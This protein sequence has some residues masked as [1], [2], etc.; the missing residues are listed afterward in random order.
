M[1]LGDPNAPHLVSADPTTLDDLFRHAAARR[2]DAVA[3]CD[4]PNRADCVDGEP[5]RLT[6]EQA[7]H[8]VSAIAGR[9]RRLG[10]AT[11]AVVALQLPN[12]VDSVLTLLGVLRAGLI[13]APLP[14]LW[15]RADAAPALNRIG[16]KA[17]ITTSR[18][19]AADH[20]GIAMNVAA[21]VFPI[22]YVCSFGESLPDGVVPLDDLLADSAVA[23]S[24]ATARARSSAAAHVAAVTFELT[25]QGMMAVAR[26]HIE[27]IAGGR[28]VLLEG[29]LA[30]N[31]A[32]LACCGGASFAGLA[33]APYPGCS[34]AAR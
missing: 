34:P 28:A 15:R 12:T 3:L 24:G 4:P 13:A 30:E 21:E 7:D 2:P 8:A 11:D 20:C 18:I 6:Y 17:I 23:R 22:R 33:A 5:R 27:M 29:G 10:L 31:A 16:A 26:N 1:I 19:G 32:I 25:P 14:L 9:L